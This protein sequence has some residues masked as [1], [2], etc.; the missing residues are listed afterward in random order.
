MQKKPQITLKG[1]NNK[2]QGEKYI[3]KILRRQGKIKIYERNGF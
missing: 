3:K 1:R 2:R